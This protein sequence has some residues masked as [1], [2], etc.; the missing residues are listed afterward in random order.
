MEGPSNF[1]VGA[2]AG[3][4]KKFFSSKFPKNIDT[5]AQCLKFHKNSTYN[6]YT[7]IQYGSLRILDYFFILSAKNTVSVRDSAIDD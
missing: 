7:Q 5:I 6:V 2:E 3:V 1:I 4:Q